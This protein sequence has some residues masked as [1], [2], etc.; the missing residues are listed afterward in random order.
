MQKEEKEEEPDLSY[1]CFPP[2]SWKQIRNMYLV[3][4]ALLKSNCWKREQ[5]SDKVMATQCFTRIYFQPRT[6]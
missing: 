6:N 4:S 2:R 3:T 5:S 1:S